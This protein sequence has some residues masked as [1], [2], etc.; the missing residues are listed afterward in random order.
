MFAAGSVISGL[1]FAASTFSPNIFCLII[2]YGLLGG[3]GFGF[4]YMSGIILVSF[5]F[6]KRL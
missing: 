6:E 3:I 5:Y 1:S 4:V 2:V